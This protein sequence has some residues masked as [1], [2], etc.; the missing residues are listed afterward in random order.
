MVSGR[1]P[2]GQS[3]RLPRVSC[4]HRNQMRTTKSQGCSNRWGFSQLWGPASKVQGS[5]GWLPGEASSRL[6]DGDSCRVPGGLF[7]KHRER[8]EG[9]SR[10]SPLKPQSWRL[11]PTLSTSS[12][13]RY[14]LHSLPPDTSQP[15]LRVSACGLGSVGG[16]VRN[17]VQTSRKT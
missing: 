13:L 9:R 1:R 3:A 16:M 14:L 4:R 2:H 15:G 12:D 8:E 6:A 7:S 11:A 5:T 17:S 10:V